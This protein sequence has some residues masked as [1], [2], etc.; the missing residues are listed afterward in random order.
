MGEEKIKKKN[1]VLGDLETQKKKNKNQNGSF[2]KD[3][4]SP[5]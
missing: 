4:R 2:G 1:G 3:E 5:M